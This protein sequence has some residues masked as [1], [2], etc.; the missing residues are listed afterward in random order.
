MPWLRLLV[1][2]L[3]RRNFWFDHSPIYVG[4]VVDDVALGQVYF[5]NFGLPLSLSSSH[6][7]I[8]IYL[9]RRLY[10]LSQ[11]RKN[12]RLQFAWAN[13]FLTVAHNICGSTVWV[14]FYVTFLAP[15]I[16]SC[17]LHFF[18]KIYVFLVLAIDNAFK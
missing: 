14:L 8:L 2:R 5:R 3:L 1:A 12:P 7:L 15:R 18:W 17:F 9:P 4:F 6:C 10:C 13:K 11:G 16:L